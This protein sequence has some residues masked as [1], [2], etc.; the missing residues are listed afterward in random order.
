[1]VYKN[2]G[3]A[4][5]ILDTHGDV[6]AVKDHV[7]QSKLIKKWLENLMGKAWFDDNYQER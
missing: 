3:L 1:M 4:V 6:V 2:G 7:D 5:C